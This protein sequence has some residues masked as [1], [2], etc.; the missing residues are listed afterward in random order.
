M[1]GMKCLLIL[2]DSMV[3]I[4][5]SYYLLNATNHILITFSYTGLEV[6][7]MQCF[8]A[9]GGYAIYVDISGYYM[10]SMVV[11]ANSDFTHC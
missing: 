3:V 2:V 4:A 11:I 7:P 6:D 9:Q 5:N 10:D 1:G 8:I